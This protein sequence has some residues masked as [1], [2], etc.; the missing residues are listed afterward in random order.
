MSISK[1]DEIGVNS[2][3]VKKGI[4]W[5]QNGTKKGLKNI[6]KNKWKQRY[7][8]LTNSYFACFKKEKSK[9]CEM[10]LFLFKLS[11]TDIKTVTMVND[12]L[13]INNDFIILWDGNNSLITEW[14][15][16]INDAKNS[17]LKRTSSNSSLINS[18]STPVLDTKRLNRIS[19]LSSYERRLSSISSSSSSS[20]LIPDPP[21]FPRLAPQCKGVISSTSSHFNTTG[22]PAYH[23]KPCPFTLSI[24][25]SLTQR[26]L[27]AQKILSSSSSPSPTPTHSRFFRPFKS[28]LTS[29]TSSS[30]LHYATQPRLQSSS[31]LKS[32]ASEFSF[33]SLSSSGASS[34]ASAAAKAQQQQQQQQKQLQQQST[35]QR[36]LNQNSHS[37][38]HQT[39][40]HQTLSR[41]TPSLPSFSGGPPSTCPSDSPRFLSSS[42]SPSH[43][44][45]DSD[46]PPPPPVPPPRI[47]TAD[48]RIRPSPPTRQQQ[49]P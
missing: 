3:I 8:I 29:T 7:F 43:G 44:S 15:N 4:L 22:P 6:F 21:T 2:R 1:D 36:H 46:S 27:Y 16:C 14:F 48:R 9:I 26:S 42:Q 30:F 32:A 34:Q 25:P 13:N 17:C 39:L 49:L 19:V 41:H 37:T 33:I 38:L 5:Q 47:G 20:H 28:S 31:N 12:T 24:S 35:P 10:G 11:L 45:F 23:L 40:L 18:K